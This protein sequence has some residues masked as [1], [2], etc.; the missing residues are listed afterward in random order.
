MNSPYCVRATAHTSG[1][2]DSATLRHDND[3]ISKSICSVPKPWLNH[4]KEVS[5]GR[6]PVRSAGGGTTSTTVVDGGEASVVIC[7]PAARPDSTNKTK[8]SATMPRLTRCAG[9]VFE[10]ITP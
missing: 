10:A 5:A 3:V 8:T 6:W 2:I 1:V 4:D 9:E 7:L